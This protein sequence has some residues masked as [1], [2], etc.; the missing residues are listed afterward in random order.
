MHVNP[1]NVQISAGIYIIIASLSHGL[2]PLSVCQLFHILTLPQLK[3]QFYS[4]FDQEDD[5]VFQM[6][7]N[8]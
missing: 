6:D 8:R 4:P 1:E 5:K 2:S 7:I 3:L